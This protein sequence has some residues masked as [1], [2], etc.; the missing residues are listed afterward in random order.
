MTPGERLAAQK[1]AKAII[2]ARKRG[3]PVMEEQIL[4]RASKAGQWVSRYRNLW[5]IGGII[6][7]AVGAVVAF[8]WWYMAERSHKATALLHAAVQ[9]TFAEI[10]GPNALAASAQGTDKKKQERFQSEDARAKKAI[11]R[12]SKVIAEYPSSDAAAWAKLG[13]AAQFMALGNVAK[14]S[15][16]Y[17]EVEKAAD[18]PWLRRAAIEGLIVAKEQIKDYEAAQRYAK[19]LLG[20]N[21]GA[22]KDA[23]EYHLARIAIHQGDKAGAAKRLKTLIERFRKEDASA[24]AYLLEQSEL[25]LLDI[26]PEMLPGGRLTKS[27]Q[28]G[29][30]DLGGLGGPGGLGGAE[31]LNNLSPE[32]LKLLIEQLQRQAPA[33]G[34]PEEP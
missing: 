21:E 5:L 3:K 4:R 1:A 9:T 25:A 2:K 8:E 28:N 19:T 10:G 18:E 17:A 34:K 31:G 24:N 13:Q 33:S 12:Y 14:A 16:R 6:F 29:L 15:A 27:G 23:A 11:E 32:Q 22:F 7:V 26:D 20:L 30:G